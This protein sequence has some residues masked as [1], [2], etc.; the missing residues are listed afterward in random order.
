MEEL[1][2]CRDSIQSYKTSDED[3]VFGEEDELEGL[4]TI[5]NT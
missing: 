4:L 1:W 5:R 3:D 2:K